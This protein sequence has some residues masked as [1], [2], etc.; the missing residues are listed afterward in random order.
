MKGWHCL[1]IT[2]VAI[3][4]G[5]TIY[6]YHR[7]GDAVKAWSTATR[8]ASRSCGGPLTD[9]H[10]WFRE[11]RTVELLETSLDGHHIAIFPPGIAGGGCGMGRVGSFHTELLLP[12]ELARVSAFAGVEPV[13][14]VTSVNLYSFKFDDSHVPL[15]LQLPHVERFDLNGTCITQTGVDVLSEHFPAAEIKWMPYKLWRPKEQERWAKYDRPDPEPEMEFDPLPAVIDPD[16]LLGAFIGTPYSSVFLEPD[17]IAPTPVPD[18]FGGALTPEPDPFGVAP[19]DSFEVGD[20]PFEFVNDSTI[21]DNDPFAGNALFSSAD[22]SQCP[23]AMVR[24]SVLIAISQ[25]HNM[26]KRKSNAR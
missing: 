22:N 21:G 9:E 14:V 3:L 4:I 15:L 5:A 24:G 23:L 17:I 25:R 7:D 8:P 11:W 19:Q 16:G 10:R 6:V 13:V 1:V 2:G 18:P 12:N 20:D 26:H